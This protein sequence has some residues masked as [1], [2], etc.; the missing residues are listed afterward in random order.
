MRAELI[1][2]DEGGRHTGTEQTCRYRRGR[3]KRSPVRSSG[4]RLPTRAV[5]DRRRA[6]ACTPLVPP[7]AHRCHMCRASDE[8]QAAMRE[9][10][11]KYGTMRILFGRDKLDTIKGIPQ[12][13]RAFER[14]LQTYPEWQ[15][16]VRPSSC[17]AR[18]RNCGPKPKQLTNRELW[19]IL[20]PGPHSYVGRL[21]AGV[22]AHERAATAAGRGQ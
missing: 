13:L 3:H 14:F 10:Q 21:G 1:Q 16:K 11:S 18:S 9:L 5:I 6:S 7:C 19:V 15:G 22:A 12:K 4:L 17:S 2:A 8:V 20:G